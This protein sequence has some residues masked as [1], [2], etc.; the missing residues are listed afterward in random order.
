MLMVFTLSSFVCAQEITCVDTDNGNNWNTKGQTYIMTDGVI[1]SE[2]KE[3]LCFSSEAYPNGIHEY[4]CDDREQIDSSGG[5]CPN[6]CKDGACI[7]LQDTTQP[8]TEPASIKCVDTDYGK[9]YY[10]K[11]M[12]YT[13]TTQGLIE[14]S[15]TFEDE[16]FTKL[17]DYPNG[18]Q[19][20]FCSTLSNM[21]SKAFDC[22][23]GCEDGVCT[24]TSDDVC[25]EDYVCKEGS[26]SP[27]GN[28]YDSDDGNDYYVKG[29]VS[30]TGFKKGELYNYSNNDVCHGDTETLVEYSCEGSHYYTCPYGCKDGA[31]MNEKDSCDG[32]KVEDICYQ[33]GHRK[34]SNFCSDNKEFI[35]QIEDAT[36]CENNFECKSNLCIDSECIE[37][38]L[39]RSFMNWF[40]GLFG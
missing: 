40:K 12:T 9:N 36:S 19:E 39:F 27:K 8:D 26:C 24:C 11:G 29:T 6:G 28:C 10:R 25:G 32:C 7:E 21:D 34:E 33:I 30:G 22:P 3:D 15:D 38:G 20:Y 31:C 13:Q 4:H 16:C 17:P 5:E 14:F 35:P 1:F 18:V 37:S 23:N 2:I